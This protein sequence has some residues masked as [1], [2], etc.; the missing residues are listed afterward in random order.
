MHQEDLKETNE[1]EG[2]EVEEYQ[3]EEEEGEH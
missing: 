3:G 2:E 1:M